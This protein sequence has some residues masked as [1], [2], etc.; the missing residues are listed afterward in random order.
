MTSAHVVYSILS[1]LKDMESI[2]S[3]YPSPSP[4]SKG[5]PNGL[6]YSA[7]MTQGISYANYQGIIANLISAR[8]VK[9]VANQLSLT[10]KGK[11][12]ANLMDNQLAKPKPD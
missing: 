10:D 12:L 4:D 3:P 2:P 1:T 5:I 11:E 9:L 8:L 7:L 6:V